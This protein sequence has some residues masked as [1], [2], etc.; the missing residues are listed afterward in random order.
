MVFNWMNEAWSFKELSGLLLHCLHKIY[1]IPFVSWKS[2]CHLGGELKCDKM[3]LV[4]KMSIFS[5]RTFNSSQFYVFLNFRLFWAFRCT[6]NV[7]SVETVKFNT[8]A[9]C[10]IKDDLH[11]LQCESWRWLFRSK[12]IKMYFKYIF[13]TNTIFLRSHIFLK[14]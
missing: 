14:R 12:V 7:H 5:K 4:F 3:S 2:I 11:T 6:K 8:H 10:V 1:S 13:I 9:R